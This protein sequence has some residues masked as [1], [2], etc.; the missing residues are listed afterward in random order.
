MFASN[1]VEPQYTDDEG[2]KEIGSLTVPMPDT[3]GDTGRRVKA[4]FKFGATKITVEGLD[5]TSKIFVDVK[6]DFLENKP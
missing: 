2:C 1:A 4:N 6:I 3:K 5:E